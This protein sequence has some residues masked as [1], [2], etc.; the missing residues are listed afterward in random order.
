MFSAFFRWISFDIIIILIISVHDLGAGFKIGIFYVLIWN[1]ST[2]FI[3]DNNP[4]YPWIYYGIWIFVCNL[5]AR[6]RYKILKYHEKKK[7]KYNCCYLCMFEK[8]QF[9]WVCHKTLCSPFC[10]RVHNGAPFSWAP[11][12]FFTFKP[13]KC[14]F[15]WKYD[16]RGN[17]KIGDLHTKHIFHCDII[18]IA[19]FTSVKHTADSFDSFFP[20]G[21]LETIVSMNI[22]ILPSMH[23]FDHIHTHIY[24][25][26]KNLDAKKKSSFHLI[27]NA[28]AH[29]WKKLCI[30]ALCFI[31]CRNGSNSKYKIEF[32]S[33]N[34]LRSFGHV[35]TMI[36]RCM[37]S[38]IDAI[39]NCLQLRMY[40]YVA[41]KSIWQSAIDKF[42]QKWIVLATDMA[43]EIP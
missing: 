25:M 35:N 38:L 39:I 32:S 7:D 8:I 23:I 43:S 37:D 16:E 18:V 9:I 20:N 28:F 13:K 2:L 36:F 14:I 6:F 33:K 31:H 3:M 1:R 19:Y 30:F 29:I 11:H 42:I 12:F 21:I 27:L 5:V 10:T 26:S 34:K 41:E 4:Y 22:S 17:P 15:H 24:V 40:M